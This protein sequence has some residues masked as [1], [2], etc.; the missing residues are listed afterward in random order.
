MKEGINSLFSEGQ[1]KNG[2][3][4]CCSF[5]TK[6]VKRRENLSFLSLFSY[7]KLLLSS[8]SS[9]GMGGRGDVL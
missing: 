1:G 6:T 3:G 4:S 2:R 7:F 8:S 5:L 9:L